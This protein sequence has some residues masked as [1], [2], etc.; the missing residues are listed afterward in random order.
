[1]QARPAMTRDRI[2]AL[3]AIAEELGAT[4]VVANAAA[5]AERIA[6][7]R[8]YVACV[9]QFKRGKSMLLNALAGTSALPV[10]VVPVT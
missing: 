6:A 7:Q 9:G 2:D 8:F 1:M 10:G 3:A 5:L 4:E